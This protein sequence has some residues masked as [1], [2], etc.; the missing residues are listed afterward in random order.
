MGFEF[1]YRST[2][3]V[4]STEAANIEQAA[5]EVTR[6]HTWLS[7][8]PLILSASEEDGH[9]EGGSKPTFQPHPDDATTAA[10]EGLPD[11]TIQDLIEILRQLSQSHAI[12]WEISHDHSDGPIGYIRNGVCDSEVLKQSEAFARLSGILENV[13]GEFE[14]PTDIPPASFPTRQ[15]NLDDDEDGPPIL[16]F[17]PKGQ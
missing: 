13:W 15:V 10:K 1:Y 17:K 16:K 4:T 9:L 7:C 8:E 5:D 14:S 3:P 2:R 6:G 12:D 11:G